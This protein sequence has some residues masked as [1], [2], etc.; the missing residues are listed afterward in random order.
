MPI[1][2]FMVSDFRLLLR[3]LGD[4]VSQHPQ[5]FEWA[6]HS[7]SLDGLTEVLTKVRPDLLLLDID[8][9]PAQMPALTGSLHALLHDMRM[10]LLTRLN[11]N[12]LQDRCIM[13]GARGVID[14][15][16]SPEHC[17]DAIEKIHQGQIW[18]NRTA[19]ARVF[20]EFARQASG[21]AKDA[22]DDQLARLTEREQEIVAYIAR[23]HTEPGK[24]VARSLQI[25]E[26]TL[27]NHLT[28]IYEKLGVTNSHGLVA[29]AIQNRLAE[30]LGPL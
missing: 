1:R 3:G 6:G 19:T 29:Y 22:V 25:G 14:C 16:I 15:S 10:L 30:R 11:N 18:L 26:S 28:S 12:E 23:N 8:T 5:R 27:R 7:E 21:M 13:A 2:I 9:L 4:L 20:V 24:T 17:L